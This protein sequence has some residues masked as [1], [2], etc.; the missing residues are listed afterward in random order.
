VLV[1]C[2]DGRVVCAAWNS[3]QVPRDGGEQLGT[4]ALR[5]GNQ[6]HTRNEPLI[7]RVVHHRLRPALRDPQRA[8]I[9]HSDNLGAIPVGV[10]DCPA[11]GVRRRSTRAPQPY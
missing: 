8:G 10:D 4:G 3:P 2:Q 5:T 1:Q 11:D 9:D 6:C 7:H